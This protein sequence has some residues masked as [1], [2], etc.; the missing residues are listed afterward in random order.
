MVVVVVRVGWNLEVSVDVGRSD[1]MGSRYEVV[2]KWK[3]SPQI[4]NALISLAGRPPLSIANRTDALGSNN[5]V[6]YSLAQRYRRGSSLVPH[7]QMSPVLTV[8]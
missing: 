4:V 8:P 5:K 2:G 7:R 6:I 3:I 1:E